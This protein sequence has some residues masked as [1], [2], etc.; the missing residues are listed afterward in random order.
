LNIIIV[1]IIGLGTVVGLIFLLRPWHLRWGATDDEV[2][3]SMA[4]D[5]IL[6]NPTYVTT[7]A[8]TIHAP[9]SEVWPWLVQMGHRRGGLYTYDTIDR[10]MGV[11]DGPS[12]DR[13]LPEFQ[14]LMVGDVIPMGQGPDWPVKSIEPERSLV[15]F[16]DMPSMKFSW[17]WELQ[18]SNRAQTRLILRIRT[19]IT[20]VNPLMIPIFHLIDFGSFLMTRKHLLG[21]KERVEANPLRFES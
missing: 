2:K 13:I 11:L 3:R 20:K 6:E 9:V 14:Q 4:G 7:R 19:F 10:L 16:I 8:I 1:I 18:E 21:I 5:E 15:V 12:A 17:C